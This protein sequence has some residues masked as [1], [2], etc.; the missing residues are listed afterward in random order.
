MDGMSIYS[1]AS[2]ADRRKIRREMIAQAE[3][4]L[5][6]ELWHTAKSIVDQALA[7]E[8]HEQNDISDSQQSA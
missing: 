1:Q 8:R 3:N 2:K 7:K 6:A 4:L 5:P